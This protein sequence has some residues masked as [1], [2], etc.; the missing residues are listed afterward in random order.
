M[1]T[2]HHPETEAT[3]SAGARPG[4]G[5][6]ASSDLIRL[7]VAYNDALDRCT[8]TGGANIDE[9]MD[10]F[11]EDAVWVSV[12]GGRRAERYAESV[13][14]I[15]GETLVGREAIRASF[16]RRAGRYQQ[17]AELQGIDVWGDLVICRGERRDTTFAQEGLERQVRILL[18]KG[19]K[20]AQVTVVVDPEAFE[21]M[22]GGVA[23]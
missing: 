4:I 12:S 16:L 20:I 1:A 6:A 21:R 14:L 7:A 17:V 13:G 10:L 2:D 18:V 3:G 23:S 11:A 15:G 22:R 9:V 19:G 8:R 5:P